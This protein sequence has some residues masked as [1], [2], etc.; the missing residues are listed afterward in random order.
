LTRSARTSASGALRSAHKGFGHDA[1]QARLAHQARY[2]FA[3]HP[4]AVIVA[5]LGMNRPSTVRILALTMD[6]VNARQQPDVS[7]AVMHDADSSLNTTGVN[8]SGG[9]L[10]PNT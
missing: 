2:T 6:R 7:T 9:M 10:K 5:Q 8:L 4:N 1:L 3:T